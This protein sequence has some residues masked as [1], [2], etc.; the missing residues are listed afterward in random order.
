MKKT[1][2]FIRHAEGEHNVV[3]EKDKSAYLRED[4]I[5]AVLSSHGFNQCS[6]F[7][8]YVT[9]IIIRLWL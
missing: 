5:D 9:Q 1:L 8:K 3:G 2:H 6:N 7:H 4:L